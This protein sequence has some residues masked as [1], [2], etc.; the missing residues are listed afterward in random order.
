M[1]LDSPD[2]SSIQYQNAN[3][4][5]RVSDSF[6]GAVEGDADWN[7]TA[8]VDG[9]VVETLKARKL[10]RDMAEA[11][12][13]CADPGIQYDTTINSWH[14]L[15]NTGRIN[16][17]NPCFPG[18]ARVHT[19]RGLLTFR[20]LYD[21]ASEGEELR[22]YTHRA[23][24]TEPGEGVVATKPLVVMQNGVKPIVRLRFSN[25]QELRCTPNHRL[26][27]LNRGYVEAADLAADDQVL[28]N[29]SPT[30]AEDASWALPVKVEA[31]AVSR[32]GGTT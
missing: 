16:A 7:L 22:V 27:T 15:P 4:S 13:R 31:L 9:S 23:T 28:V 14:T 18:D 3:N 17:S 20:E 8:R 26:W 29:D 6:M 25:G 2:W 30:R 32:S 21:L 1:S 12:W 5:V 24:A 11:A 10:M 19:T